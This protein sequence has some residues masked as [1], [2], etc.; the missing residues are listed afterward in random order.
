MIEG[1]HRLLQKLFCR[2]DHFDTKAQ[3]CMRNLFIVCEEVNCQLDHLFST[4]T[5][6]IAKL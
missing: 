5:V 1:F 6:Y 2:T 4:V 3:N